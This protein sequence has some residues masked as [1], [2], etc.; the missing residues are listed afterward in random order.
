MVTK[1]SLYLKFGFLCGLVLVI[2]ILQIIIMP[3]ISK[4]RDVHIDEVR[5]YYTALHYSHDGE[6]N[7]VALEPLY[8]GET[9]VGYN[10]TFSIHFSN[11]NEDGITQRDISYKIYTKEIKGTEDNYYVEGVWGR[12]IGVKNDTKKYTVNILNEGSSK[13]TAVENELI[14]YATNNPD[15]SPTGA[16][17]LHIIELTRNESAGTWDPNV[18]YEEVT[19]IIEL[20]NPYHEIIIFNVRTSPRLIVYNITQFTKFNRTVNRLFIQTANTWDAIK[21]GKDSY[22]PDAF[23]VVLHWQDLSFDN[24]FNKILVHTNNGNP[25]DPAKIITPCLITPQIITSQ[26]TLQMYI[27]AGSEFY[28][29]FYPVG[30]NPKIYAYAEL[31]LY[32]TYPLSPSLE[33]GAY[34]KYDYNNNINVDV[35]VM[36]GNNTSN[37]IDAYLIQ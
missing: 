17:N 8:S 12:H 26:K 22:A 6:G 27:P 34:D 29:D 11:F 30:N 18:E 19:I 31:K 36:I 2:I 16:T 10:G 20:I 7:A 28:I 24:T 32:A 15:A 1:K 5:G 21:K 4:L 9:I 14:S 13:E 23:R 35:N 3:T 33:Y 37:N 25:V